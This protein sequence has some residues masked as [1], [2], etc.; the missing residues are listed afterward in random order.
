M[1][2]PNMLNA[3][4]WLLVIDGVCTMYISCISSRYWN[5][6]N[7]KNV[8]TKTSDW[9]IH[10][11]CMCVVLVARMNLDEIR[12]FPINNHFRVCFVT[13]NYSF[14]DC[15]INGR[16][17]RK[18]PSQ[19]AKTWTIWKNQTAFNQNGYIHT[20]TKWWKEKWRTH[21]NS[22]GKWNVKS[23]F[24]QLRCNQIKRSDAYHS[25]IGSIGN[26]RRTDAFRQWNRWT[27][28]IL[29]IWRRAERIDWKY[30]KQI[31]RLEIEI[32]HVHSMV[33]LLGHLLDDCNWAEIWN[34][35]FHVFG[36]VWCIF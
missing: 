8:T 16:E 12:Q 18:V 32:H 23:S 31:R 7:S 28:R 20:I 5:N 15:G 17:I 21:S 4:L 19:C 26:I 34:C 33:L 3:K 9:Q 24:F 10:N 1:E 35:I 14:Q 2:S 27:T 13:F 6:I 22:R 30:W 11:V 29:V 36:T 25:L